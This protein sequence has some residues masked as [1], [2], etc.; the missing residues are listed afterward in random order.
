MIRNDLALMSQSPSRYLW[1]QC[2]A[3]AGTCGL[4]SHAPGYAIPS[5]WFDRAIPDFDLWV[6]FE[7]SAELR[8]NRSSWQSLQRGSCLW[9]RPG[10]S[11]E[12]RV[13]GH[14]RLEMG[15]THFH[16]TTPRGRILRPQEVA[17]E[18]L[19]AEASDPYLFEFGIRRL[20]YLT[21]RQKE[22]EE[23]ALIAQQISHL[24]HLLLSE[25]A[26]QCKQGGQPVAPGLAAHHLQVATAASVWIRQ[27]PD[28]T[29][30]LA[31]LASRFGY[32]E[33]YFTRIFRQQMGETPRQALTRAKID[34]ARQLL[35]SSAMNIG[36]IAESLG[37]SSLYY[38]SRHFAK[39][40]GIAPSIY[41]DRVA[42]MSKRTN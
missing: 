15:F 36:E 25:Y 34:H 19:R 4:A 9:F 2:P 39:E 38:F 16:F 42:N 28:W 29:G 24:L 32:N 30:T 17:V 13:T 1:S 8:V 18:P 22:G 10:Q 11:Y 12:F 23:A 26:L 35:T 37:Y 21:H 27:H 7:G 20:L 41:R 14:R 33:R 5:E 3:A 6:I 40:V 31:D